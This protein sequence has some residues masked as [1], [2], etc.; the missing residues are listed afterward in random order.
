MKIV[1]SFQPVRSHIPFVHIAFRVFINRPAENAQVGLNRPNGGTCH[2]AQMQVGGNCHT[3]AALET[4][5]QNKLK[6][7]TFTAVCRSVYKVH[8]GG[9]LCEK[10]QDLGVLECK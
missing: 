3:V 1:V 10:A 7:C 8:R 6:Q 2:D 5:F 9:G 4:C